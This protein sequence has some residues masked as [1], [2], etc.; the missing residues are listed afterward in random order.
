MSLPI[1]SLSAFIILSL[2]AG[3]TYANN[4]S[5]IYETPDDAANA[6]ISA[7]SSDG[8]ELIDVTKIDKRYFDINNDG[9]ND[10]WIIYPPLECG[11]AGC[12]GTLYIWTPQGYCWAGTEVGLHHFRAETFPDGIKCRPEGHY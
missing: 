6:Y 3:I 1:R 5:F 11:S 2:A 12:F 7:T 10:L 4:A 9:N 8:K